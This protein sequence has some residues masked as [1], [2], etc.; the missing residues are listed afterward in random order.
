MSNETANKIEVLDSL[1][2]FIDKQTS[3]LL[4]PHS[5]WQVQD[6]IPDASA[7]QFPFVAEEIRAEALRL[8]ASVLIDVIGNTITED[9]LPIFMYLVGM[10]IGATG[11]YKDFI[12]NP[13][14]T[15]DQLG[16]TISTEEFTDLMGSK[17][18]GRWTLGWGAQ[19]NRHGKLSN[20]Y[21][22]LI[23]QINKREIAR[24]VQKYIGAGFNP[25]VSDDIYAT[26]FYPGWQ[27]LA[28]QHSHS[29]VSWLGHQL[30]APYLHRIAGAMG[31][32]E[33]RHALFYVPLGR[34]IF[35]ADPAGA[36]LSFARLVRDRVTMAGVEMEGFDMFAAASSFSG[37]YGIREYVGVFGRL[38]KEWNIEGLPVSGDAAKAQEQILRLHT[39]LLRK[40]NR[41]Q[42][43][44]NKTIES[45]WINTQSQIVL[46]GKGELVAG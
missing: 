36:I 17:A 16:K 6:F 46:A 45:P 14:V 9:G 30:G 23:P 31:E 15:V 3:L 33:G 26:L 35:K 37:V 38:I 18:L 13:P 40:A 29:G 8:P 42:T 5:D 10:Y 11:S 20:R 1:E 22:D 28:T 21:L 4:R 25:G 39:I 43:I 41:A 19:E 27:E 12:K 7:L 32:E 34:E 24:T 2:P 44:E